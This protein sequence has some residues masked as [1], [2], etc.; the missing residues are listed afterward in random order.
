MLYE[1]KAD[2]SSSSAVKEQIQEIDFD[3]NRL[4]GLKDRAHAILA[5]NGLTIEP[6]V[7]IN[8][9]Y[10]AKDDTQISLKGG[11]TVKLLDASDSD[12]WLVEH[13]GKQG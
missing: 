13:E 12:W 4:S 5:K 9:N 1:S 3:I 11:Q 10:D 6:Q 7:I 2:Q 8:W